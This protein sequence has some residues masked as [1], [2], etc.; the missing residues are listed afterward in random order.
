[1]VTYIHKIDT[2]L[3]LIPIANSIAAI[4]YIYIGIVLF[5]ISLKP[6]KQRLKAIDAFFQ[7]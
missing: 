7:K 1:M 5:F 2:P 4:I 6:I 3:C